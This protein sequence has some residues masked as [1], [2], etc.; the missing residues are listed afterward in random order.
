[1]CIAVPAKLISIEPGG[2]TGKVLYSGNELTVNLSLVTP[3]VDEYLLIHAGCAIGTVDK[4]PAEE[5]LD[6]FKLLEDAAYES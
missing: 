2:H 3:K 5:L 1:M 4:Q 6:V